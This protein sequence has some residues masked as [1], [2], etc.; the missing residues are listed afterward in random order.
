MIAEEFRIQFL[1]VLPNP[2]LT[3]ANYVCEG[4]VCVYITS[5]ILVE[6]SASLLR[7][8]HKTKSSNQYGKQCKILI[9]MLRD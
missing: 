6:M 5:I 7:L 3:Q 1:G 8:I 9:S 2:W 4:G